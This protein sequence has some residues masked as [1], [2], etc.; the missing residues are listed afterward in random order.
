MA[1]GRATPARCNEFGAG[2]WRVAL[3][4][5]S[6]AIGLSLSQSVVGAPPVTPDV[7]VDV[8][9]IYSGALLELDVP[10][11]AATAGPSRRYPRRASTPYPAKGHLLPWLPLTIVAGSVHRSLLYTL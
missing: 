5:P 8:G 4:W 10:C 9:L 7:S 11:R 1:D 3:I 2:C 6:P